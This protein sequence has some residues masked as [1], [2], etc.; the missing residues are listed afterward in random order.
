MNAGKLHI[1]C[2]NLLQLRRT[3]PMNAGEDFYT[4]ALG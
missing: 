1:H 2:C 4:A 3:R